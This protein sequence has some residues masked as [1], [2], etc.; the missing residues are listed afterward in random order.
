MRILVTGATGFIGTV[1]VD[2]LL[3]Q[4]HRITVLSRDPDSAAAH[5]NQRVTAIRDI[6]RLHQEDAPEAIINLA[7]EPLANG[8]WTTQRKQVI[9]NSRIRLTRSIAKYVSLRH[10]RPR[11]LI[12]GS[13]I[14]YYGPHGDEELNER[15]H[16]AD[17]FAAT[18]CRDW[19]R[20]ARKAE[21]FGVRVCLLRTGLV[22]GRKHRGGAGMLGR[23]L[24]VF[25][26]GLGGALGN[27]RQWM[28]WIHINDLI[29]LIEHCLINDALQGPINGT[30]PT[31]VRNNAFTHTLGQLLHR[32]TPFRTPAIA[33]RL[34]LGEMSQLLLDGQRVIP[35]HALD[36]GFRFRFPTLDLAL[37]EILYAQPNGGLETQVG[38][39]PKNAR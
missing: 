25:R 15:H 11:V 14:G 2:R 4:G 32:W 31:P 1:L 27:G 36:S 10:T 20:E 8:R 35:Q 39:R 13:A 19:E 34:L 26:M 37:K 17:D 30:A 24:P 7:G 6:F 18:L 12:S 5:F 21:P 33:L 9:Y 22:L 16:P 38:R 28:S 23:L 3:Q 29:G